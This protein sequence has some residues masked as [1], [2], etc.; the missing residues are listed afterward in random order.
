ML[1]NIFRTLLMASWTLI[2][3]NTSISKVFRSTTPPSITMTRLWKV[4][5]S[6]LPMVLT[7]TISAPSLAALQYYNNVININE[8]YLANL[9]ARAD[10][11]GYTDFVNKWTT[12]FPPSGPIPPAPS[13]ALPGCD[14]Y[15]DIYNAAYYVNP[16]FNIYHLTD[17]CPFLWDE[18]GF[19]SLAGGPNNYFNRS[20]VQAV[21]HAPPTDYF[22]CAGGPNLFP[23]GDQSIPSALGPLP[24]V[25]ERTNNTIIGH[26]MLDFLLF[27]NGTLITIQN[28][29]WN[30]LQGFQ[31]APSPHENFFVPY[32]QSLGYILSVAN[33]A[34]PNLPGVI[35]TAGAGYQGTTHTE[36]GLTFVTVTLAGHEIPQYVPGAAYRQLEFLLGRIESLEQTGDFTT[37]P[38]G[39][40]TGVAPPQRRR[41]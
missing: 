3:P 5:R 13:S 25:I 8:T 14:I 27:A 20:D 22:I 26:G 21:I 36:R 41:V 15:D 29:T 30:G 11:C 17:Y 19:P 18:L 39:N 38:Q 34:I 35:D 31:T 23:D 24:S 10:E 37:G 33:D 12:E 16:C 2:T 32:H 40:Y 1:G 6:T 7:L 9:T 4:F 28:M